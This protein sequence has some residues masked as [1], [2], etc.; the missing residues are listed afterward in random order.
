[1]RLL[2]EFLF[3]AISGLM[4][5]ENAGG[6]DFVL[7][8]D[9]NSSTQKG[10][11]SVLNSKFGLSSSSLD[12]DDNWTSV[13]AS[14]VATLAGGLDNLNGTFPDDEGSIVLLV[15]NGYDGTNVDSVEMCPIQIQSANKDGRKLNWI[16]LFNRGNC[17]KFYAANSS[18]CD[19]TDYTKKWSNIGVLTSG[20]T[21]MTKAYGV[22][23][24]EKHE[25]KNSS[26]RLFAA[27]RILN[28][29]III[30]GVKVEGFSF[31]KDKNVCSSIKSLATKGS[32]SLYCAQGYKKNSAGTDC[33]LDTCPVDD[34]YRLEHLCSGFSRDVY[35]RSPQSWQL[36]TSAT[37]AGCYR[38]SCL[39]FKHGFK[40]TSDHTCV[41]CPNR[42]GQDA[43]GL[44][45]TACP[46]GQSYQHSSENL[47]TDG[48]CV[49]DTA[50]SKTDMMYGKGKTRNSQTFEKSCWTIIDNYKACVENGGLD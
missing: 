11:S 17:V 16:R 13:D 18:G 21:E 43:S 42:S 1:M 31:K 25:F 27:S 50:Y 41:Q 12:K 28:H 33:V 19:S 46:L 4:F 15:V 10:T 22:Y 7:D 35:N 39:D 45:A 9:F 8:K 37:S 40:S 34:T 26:I 29:G 14:G 24:G 38:Y 49:N 6:V 32:G 3:V 23:T 47:L 36:T 20:G 44:C 5:V 2:K 48:A 30:K